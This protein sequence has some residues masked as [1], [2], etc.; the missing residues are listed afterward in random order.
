MTRVTRGNLTWG[1]VPSG[2]S[3]HVGS[4]GPVGSGLVRFELFHFKK[5]SGRIDIKGL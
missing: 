2:H 3:G 5:I 4:E 1:Q